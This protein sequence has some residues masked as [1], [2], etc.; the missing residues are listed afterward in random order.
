M[1]SDRQTVPSH[2]RDGEACAGAVAEVR[3]SRPERGPAPHH[4]PRAR[5]PLVS[6]ARGHIRQFHLPTPRQHRGPRHRQGQGQR[7]R[8]RV[9]SLSVPTPRSGTHVRGLHDGTPGGEGMAVISDAG[10]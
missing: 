7:V 10:R 2:L 6:D 5:V 8:V 9:P 3:C 4:R 1:A